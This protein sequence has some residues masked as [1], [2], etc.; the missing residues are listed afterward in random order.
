MTA[1]LHDENDTSLPKVTS[2]DMPKKVVIELR[3][4]EEPSTEEV[5]TEVVRLSALSVID[6]ERERDRVSAR[7]GIRK[8]TL[9]KLVE[10]ERAK[11]PVDGPGLDRE[12][13]LEWVEGSE[14]VD[15]LIADLTRYVS[16]DPDYAVTTTFWVIHTYLLE[17]T[18]ITP[19]LAITAPEPRCGKTT[20]VN[21]LRTVVQRPLNS[22]NISAAAVYHVVDEQQ[23][24]LLIDEADTFLGTNN[25]L[26]GILNSGHQQDGTVQRWDAKQKTIVSFSTFGA[27]AISLI[28]NL[29]STLQDRSIRV[30][31]RR[32]KPD[33]RIFSFRADRVDDKLARRCARWTLDNRYALGDPAIPEQLFNRVEDNWRPLLSIADAIG[34]AWPERLRA[35]AVKIAELEGGEDP[36][37]GTQLLQDI[38]EI[39]EDKIWITSG[40]LVAR[41][42]GKAWI[43]SGKK[44]AGLL[45]PYGIEPTQQRWDGRVERG[46]FVVDF[47]DAFARY[48]G[49]P[50]VPDVPVGLQKRRKS[51][52]NPDPLP[53]QVVH[54]V[55]QKSEILADSLLCRKSKCMTINEIKDAALNAAQ[56]AADRQQQRTEATR[57]VFIHLFDALF[58]CEKLVVVAEPED[59]ERFQ[60]VA[61]LLDQNVNAF[62]KAANWREE[63]EQQRAAL[64]AIGD[65]DHNRIHA[66]DR[67]ATPTES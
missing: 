36:S 60:K 64:L 57:Q 25:E 32:R 50:D 11:T 18:F 44:L 65:H 3:R 20:L 40:A 38:R 34:G 49:V 39:V 8:A 59:R 4:T 29:P 35:I 5:E 12:P 1:D 27:C 43:M 47:A 13:A 17:H 54:P 67:S 10:A 45:K 53:V 24:T 62:L 56:E 21:W 33:E 46:Y 14:L 16:L 66:G 52:L 55:Q 23:P 9:D 48:L 42:S 15:E 51:Y 26:R 61:E 41:L 6:Y 63:C 37:L 7:L 30:R 58:A 31:L 22:I 28:G 19:R 2:L